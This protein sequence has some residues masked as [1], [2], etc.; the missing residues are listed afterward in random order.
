MYSSIRQIQWAFN[1][2]GLKYRTDD[3]FG[4]QI[5]RASMKGKYGEYTFLFIKDDDEGNDVAIRTLPLV[6]VPNSRRKEAC[7][8]LNS[9]QQRY[10]YARFVIDKD[11]D[12]NVSYDFLVACQDIGECAV[13]VLMKMCGVLDACYPELMRFI[14]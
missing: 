7:I 3:L 5:L 4:N 9:F 14:W 11:G 6:R 12:V 10:R 8:L 13:D 2:K 1:K